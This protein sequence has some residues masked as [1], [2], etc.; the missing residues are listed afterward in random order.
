MPMFKKRLLVILV[1]TGLICGVITYKNYSQQSV[2][3]EDTSQAAATE[4]NSP[5]EKS[6]GK[7]VVY[8]T[9]A[10]NNPGVI[11][12]AEGARV[13]DA[14][15]KCGGMSESADP[16]NINLAMKITDGTQI[17]IPAKNSADATSSAHA[18]KQSD[19]ININYADES[20]LDKLPGV[21]PAMAKRIMEYRQTE[22]LF[23]SLDDLKKVRG[24]GN[25]K[26]NTLK[27]KITL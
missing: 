21:G 1:I 15:N 7:I 27:D 9:G 4:S 25:A 5:V 16:E 23:Q 24:I 3:L 20:E 8:V 6:N 13:I 26:F 19:K 12:L 11:E 14:I 22:G 10:V 2:T 18:D 17:K